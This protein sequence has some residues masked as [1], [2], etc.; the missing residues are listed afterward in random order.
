[1]GTL[2]ITLPGSPGQPPAGFSDGSPIYIGVRVVGQAHLVHR[3]IDWEILPTVTPFTSATGPI[4]PASR[5][6]GK[7]SAGGSQAYTVR[8][9]QTGR[10][11]ASVAATG[12]LRPRL[13]LLGPGGNTL[14]TSDGPGPNDPTASLAIYLQPG[15]YTVRVS[16]RVV[17]G[18]GGDY[19][20]TT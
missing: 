12:V 2:T 13:T 14:A 19:R 16:T 9:D 4:A 6:D 15:T 18:A 7:L 20:L 1:Q 10:Y 11:T 5:V 17:G 8:V 3:G